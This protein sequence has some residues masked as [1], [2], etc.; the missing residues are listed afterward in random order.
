MLILKAITEETEGTW[1]EREIW[2]QKIKLKIRPRTDDLTE[3]IRNRHKKINKRFGMTIPEYN[4]EAIKLDLTDHDLEDFEGL[5]DE[6]GKPLDVT[7]ETKMAVMDM[8]VPSGDFSNRT[9]V[10]E[11]A[12]EL[13]IGVS[14]A[15]AKNSKPS[16]PVSTAVGA[17]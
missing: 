5:G 13:A 7:I 4:D 10:Y 8:P 9:F 16:Q 2:G 15:E 14:D 12:A 1:V 11:K 17:Q 6:S 3:K